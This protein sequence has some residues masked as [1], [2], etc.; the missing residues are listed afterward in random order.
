MGIDVIIL[1][2]LPGSGKSTVASQMNGVVCSADEFMV[3][4]LGK[5]DFDP[6]RL[7][8]CHD[9]CFDK[10]LAVLA[11]GATPVIANT[12]TMRWEMQRYIDHCL[13]LGLRWS[14]LDLYDGGLTDELLVE[15]CLHGVDEKGM[16]RMRAR[17]ER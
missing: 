3:D 5:Y 8:E 10:F 15:R 1:R 4:E 2:G 13:E 16:K 9:K 12:N 17:Y 7:G 14:V 11:I 6:D